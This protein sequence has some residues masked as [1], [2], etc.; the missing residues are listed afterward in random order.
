[1]SRGPLRILLLVLAL[2]GPASVRAQP[3]PS[4]DPEVAAL[5]SSF[6][7]GKYA[8]VLERAGQRIDRGDLPEE[9]LVELH[10]LAGLSAFNLN[11]TDEA[12]R[13]LR[14]VLRLDPDFS[15]DPFVVP[16]PAVAFFED[17]KN[18]MAGERDFLRQEQRL[19]L[20]REKT[21]AERREQ[22]RVAL[23]TQRRRAEEL[24]RQV[25]VRTVEKRNFLVNFVPFGAGQ[26]QQGRNSM[27]IVFAATEGALAVTSIIAFFAY[28]SLFE[29]RFVNLD[30]VLDEDGRASIPVRFIPTDRARQADTW[31]LLK[32]AS[33][34]GFYTVY[35]LGVVDAVYHHEDQ[36]VT[37]TTVESRPEPKPP[38]VSMV[39]PPR[40][41]LYSTR[42]G[43][44]AGLSL[45]F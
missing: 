10:K 44:G 12:E 29:E 42:G 30:N 45:T 14:A 13:H 21:E 2:L 41:R 17:L 20:E 43:L 4:A 31:Q 18:Q 39:P 7:Y 35:T 3:V 19:R 6:E 15:L 40:L 22:E 34:T 23:E 28:D 27:G 26:F 1:M 5:R 33:A 16:P 8:E 24:A 36:V 32:L 37:S 9:D 38:A 25:T 11:R